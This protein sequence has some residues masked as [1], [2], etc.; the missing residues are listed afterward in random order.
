M[1]KKKEHLQKGHPSV[2][3][4]PMTAVMAPPQWAGILRVGRT[5]SYNDFFLILSL[6]SL[7]Y[8]RSFPRTCRTC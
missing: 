4:V 1:S 5:C 7:P 6:P 8:D 3:A 2:F